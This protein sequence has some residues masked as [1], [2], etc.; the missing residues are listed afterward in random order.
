[1]A[2]VRN[3]FVA[4]GMIKSERGFW[5][6]EPETRAIYSLL[7]DSEEEPQS[8]ALIGLRKI[9]KSSLL[10]RIANKRG[11]SDMYADQLERTACV[12]IS[13]QAMSNSSTDAFFATI[14][15]ELRTQNNEVIAQ[16]AKSASQSVKEP[17]QQLKQVLRLMDKEESLLVLLL[18]EFGCAA[19]NPVFDKSFF[20]LLRSMAQEWR[21]AF[22]VAN[23][24]TLDQLWDQS[25][26]SSPYSSPF[27]NIFQTLTLAG[28]E[29]GQSEEYLSALSRE[30]GVP[31]EDD[32][33]EIATD[34]GGWHPFFL[35]VAAYHLFQE[36]GQVGHEVAS[37][38]DAMW[39]QII[40]DPT[41]YGNLEYYWQRLTLPRKRLL[42]T[43][44]SSELK[45]APTPE[46][47]VDLGWLKRMGLIKET[48]P[49]VYELF[50]KAF[51][52][53]LLRPGLKV[54]ESDLEYPEAETTVQALISQS[55]GSNVE[56]KSSLRWDYHQ[57]KTTTIPEEAAL[58][59][60]A[61]FLNTD[62]GTLIIG[63]ND[64]GNVL[65][66]EKDY[67]S[68]KKKNC[69]G[70]ELHL[71]GLIS[72]K[73]GKAICH[74]IHPEFH[75]ID[76]LDVCKLDVDASPQA[77]YVDEDKGVAFYIRTGNST[78][79]LNVKEAVGYISQHWNAA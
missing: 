11:A 75:R 25:L 35:T 64:E 65:G 48:T 36:L 41:V 63:V 10:Y 8:A 73:L 26:L 22:V 47:Q 78:Q 62:G 19:A 69:D 3:P 37:K 12:M 51:R 71:M 79:K 24:D 1:M 50:S 20:D 67:A 28:F 7:L 5:G 45:H 14:I 72:Q 49:Q 9:G 42:I 33:I 15:E 31:F 39:T 77:V 60:L 58:K 40:Q 23:Q 70:F 27:F 56:F 44:A 16:L 54:G 13:M 61:A 57:G 6:R 59:T 17:G 76:E 34:A 18:D 21:L 68:F 32:D 52:D 2:M 38:R 53:F 29:N 46:E 43:L 74:Y 55:E 30:A 4:R 66:L